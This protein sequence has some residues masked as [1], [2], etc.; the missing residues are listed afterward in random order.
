MTNTEKIAYDLAGFR[1]RYAME[2]GERTTVTINGKKYWKF[3]YSPSV[4]YQDANG[5]MYDIKG[6]RWVG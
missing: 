2:N 4:E 5:A 6:R 3:K 1:E